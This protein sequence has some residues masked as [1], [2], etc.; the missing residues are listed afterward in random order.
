ML[1]V[2]GWRITGGYIINEKPKLL[3]SAY[4]VPEDIFDILKL[5][6]DMRADYILYLRFDGEPGLI[7]SCDY[8]VYAS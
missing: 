8:V 6:T 2:T 3:I 5:I 4:H 7:W 1:C